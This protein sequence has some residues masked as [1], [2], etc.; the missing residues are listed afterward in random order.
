MSCKL[1]LDPGSGVADNRLVNK[2]IDIVR[3]ASLAMLLIDDNQPW[4]GQ[5]AAEHLAPLAEC[6][7]GDP[8]DR[9]QQPGRRLG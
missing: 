5:D 4:A 7:R 6:R 1:N 3:S 8:L 9:K 2:R